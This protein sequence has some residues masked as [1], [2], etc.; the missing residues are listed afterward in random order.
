MGTLWKNYDKPM[1]FG[2]SYVQTKPNVVD[3]KM[4]HRFT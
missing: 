2:L 3:E 1:D 4:G